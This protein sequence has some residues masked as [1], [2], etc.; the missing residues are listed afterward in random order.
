M[1]ADVSRHTELGRER[2]DEEEKIGVV[3]FDRSEMVSPPVCFDGMD[4]DHAWIGPH[5]E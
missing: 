5:T 2:A 1:R 3:W 4:P